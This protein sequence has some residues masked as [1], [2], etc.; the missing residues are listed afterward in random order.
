MAIT[1]ASSS[2]YC[3]THWTNIVRLLLLFGQVSLFVQN[4]LRARG[5]AARI[6]TKLLTYL[7]R[8]QLCSTKASLTESVTVVACSDFSETRFE[9]SW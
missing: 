1:N 9:L 2:R 4:L 6:R 5:P 8:G 7:G 3:Q